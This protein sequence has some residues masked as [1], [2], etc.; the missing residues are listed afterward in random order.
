MPAS[1][2]AR[3]DYD[4]AADA[5][6][7]YGEIPSGRLES[8]LIQLALGDCTD[9]FVLDLGGGTGRHARKAL[10]LGAA[11]VDV[12][13]ISVGMLNA[14]QRQAE[15]DNS[16]GNCKLRFFEADVTQPLEHLP[17]LAEGYDVVMGNWIFSFAGSVVALESMFHNI[18]KHLKPG[19]RFI[20]VR[21]ADPWSPVLQSGKYGG[22][23][24][25]IRKIPGGVEYVCVLQSTP[26]VE[27]VGRC[28]ETIYS[29]SK[30]MYEKFGLREV[31]IVPYRST[32]VVQSDPD[33]WEEFLQRPCLAVVKAVAGT[34]GTE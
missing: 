16:S 6:D 8:D 9:L 3:E 7:G 14:G 30:E 10:E 26:L 20:G 19:G 5:Y 27:F 21:D 25:D 31:E 15:R 24:R 33:F 12:V 32:P 17:L 18:R 29:G 2:Q 22:I 11:G 4:R 28:L 34:G 23:C 13:D 1:E